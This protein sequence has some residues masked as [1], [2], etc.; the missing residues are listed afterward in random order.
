M[1]VKGTAI[2]IDTVKLSLNLVLKIARI[3][4]DSLVSALQLRT[5]SLS[6]N[7][8]IVRRVFSGLTV[9]RI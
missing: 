3:E 1:R 8:G 6:L 9:I 5:Q 4:N 7:W 2:R